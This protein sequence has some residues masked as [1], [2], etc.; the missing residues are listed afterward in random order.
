MIKKPLVYYPILIIIFIFSSSYLSLA[1]TVYKWTDKKGTVHFTDEKDSIPEKHQ[2]KVKKIKF[3][4][5]V[6]KNSNK[7]PVIESESNKN[8]PKKKKT[9]YKPKWQIEESKLK[10]E[11]KEKVS[12]KIDHLNKKK[13]KFNIKQIEYNELL[14]KLKTRKFPSNLKYKI[15]ALE[16]EISILKKE[17]AEINNYIKNKLPKEARKAG[18]PPGWLREWLKE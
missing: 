8:K 18:I 13:S 9:S 2:K 14:L 11:W 10:A 12:K 5:K 16:T 1:D 15:A 4:S 3:Q 17:L 6:K 7:L